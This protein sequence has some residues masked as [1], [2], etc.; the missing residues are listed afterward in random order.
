MPANTPDARPAPPTGAV[1]VPAHNEE[2]VIERTLHRLLPLLAHDTVEVIVVVNGSTDGTAAAARHVPGV[3]VIESGIG[4]KPA[5]MNLGDAAATRWP[6]LYLDADIDVEPEAVE[7][8]FRSLAD[9]RGPL[10]ARPASVIDTSASSFPV[11]AYYRA[12]ARI[13]E[14]GTRLWGAGLYAVSR[15]GHERFDAFADVTADDSWFDALFAEDEKEVLPTS[16]ARVHAP[17]NTAALL[18]ILSRHRRGYVELDGD[19]AAQ[20]TDRV[21]ALLRTIRGPRS[22][23]DAC[24]YAALAAA[25]RLR[26]RR[27]VGAGTRRWETDGT[28]RA[29][30]PAHG[31]VGAR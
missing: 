24:C 10:A 19:A 29:G 4:S 2:R 11:R 13:P 17:T 6:R 27:T 22:A 30:R 20:S 3:T 21:A 18:A 1:I 7:A 31:T 15:E 26:T 28:T 14:R 8:V 16:P 12:R 23:F 5:A 9:P 25:A